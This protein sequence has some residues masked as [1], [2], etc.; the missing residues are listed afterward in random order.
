MS[1]QNILKSLEQPNTLH[2]TDTHTGSKVEFKIYHW[3]PTKTVQRLSLIGRKFAVP[4]SMLYAE[5]DNFAE[6]FPVALL[7][8]FETLGEDADSFIKMLLDEVWL[9]DKNVSEHFDDIFARDLHL[10]IEL[11][12]KVLEI[13][14]APFLKKGLLGLTQA[15][16]PVVN[17]YQATTSAS[18]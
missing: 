10:I 1:Q 3:S 14:Y 4:I 8:F 7:Q 6:N 2:K 18:Q 15:V 13:N 17:L 9:N 11:V 16:S 5:S 12:Q